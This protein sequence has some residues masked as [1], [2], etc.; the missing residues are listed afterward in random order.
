MDDLHSRDRTAEPAASKLAALA[1][2]E[3]A[4]RRGR[5]RRTVNAPAFLILD[6]DGQ[7]L[8]C[9]M[10]NTSDT[11]ALLELKEPVSA[12][13]VFPFAKGDRS[14]LFILELARSQVVDIEIVRIVPPAM[15]VRYLGPAST[16]ETF[17]AQDVS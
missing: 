15:G 11:G 10:R 1:S 3:A 6:R 4:E 8:P 9:L 2:L 13:P 16:I 14:L 17:T 7:V 5:I 12:A